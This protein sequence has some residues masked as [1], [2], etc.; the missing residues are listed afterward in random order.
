SPDVVGLQLPSPLASKQ[1]IMG[2]AEHPQLL[3]PFLI[4]LGLPSHTSRISQT[5]PVSSVREGIT[6]ISGQT[7]ISSLF[8]PP[9]FPPSPPSS[10]FCTFPV[11]SWPTL[12]LQ[13]SSRF[14]GVQLP[15]EQEQ[16]P[17]NGSSP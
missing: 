9:I 4:R 6:K 7:N 12:G 16:G 11:Q 2:V 17:S 8:P 5:S 14:T 15:G 10:D 3:Q 13:R 1:G